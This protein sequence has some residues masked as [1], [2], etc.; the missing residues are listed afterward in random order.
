MTGSS[1]SRRRSGLPEL[2]EWLG[3]G[4]PEVPVHGQDSHVIPIEVTEGSGQYVLRAELPDIDP[5]KDAEITVEGNTL[6]IRAERT[7]RAEDKRHSEFRYGSF[8]RTVRLPFPIPEVGPTAEYRD[9]ILTVT[10]PRTTEEEP[11]TRTVPVR[12]VG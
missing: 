2:M 9:G 5:E 8:E 1:V 10:V 12:R 3:S 6:T 4:F 7:E 11:A